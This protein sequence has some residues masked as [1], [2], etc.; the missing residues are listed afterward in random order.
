MAPDVVAD[1]IAVEE[2]GEQ[3]LHLIRE[4]LSL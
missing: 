3:V 2:G 1:A 4:A